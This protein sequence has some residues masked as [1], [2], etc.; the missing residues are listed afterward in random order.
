MDDDNFSDYDD[1]GLLGTSMLNFYQNQVI[2]EDQ[3]E[4]HSELLGN[5]SVYHRSPKNLNYQE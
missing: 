2:K 3:N 5:K 4:D 1:L